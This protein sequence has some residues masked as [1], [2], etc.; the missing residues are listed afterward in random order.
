M[1]FLWLGKSKEQKK[2]EAQVSKEVHNMKNKFTADML[3]LE[4]QAKSIHL[5]HSKQLEKSEQINQNIEDLA[6]KL[7]KIMGDK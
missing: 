1:K 7:S 4:K 5:K 6:T 3:L 2:K